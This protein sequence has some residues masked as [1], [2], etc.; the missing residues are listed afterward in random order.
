MLAFT[1]L[2]ALF[3]LELVQYF[4]HFVGIYLQVHTVA[5]SPV[6]FSGFRLRT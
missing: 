6:V 4:G 5:T 2:L 3:T 1:T